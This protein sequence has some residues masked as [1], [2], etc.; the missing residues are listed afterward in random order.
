[1]VLFA[2]TVVLATV[3]LLHSSPSTATRPVFKCESEADCNLNGD[4]VKRT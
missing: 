3:A 4:C 2:R 1:M